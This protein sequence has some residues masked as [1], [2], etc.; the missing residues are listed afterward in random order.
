[1]SGIPGIPQLTVAQDGSGQS[2]SIGAALEH[3]QRGATIRVLDDAVSQT[4]YLGRATE[5]GWSSRS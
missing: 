1:M 3:A 4:R 2:A 5:T